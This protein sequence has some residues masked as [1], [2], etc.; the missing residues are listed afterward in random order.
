MK[1]ARLW[2]TW[3]KRLLVFPPIILAIIAYAW[4]VKHSP[5]L[6]MHAEEEASR[7][8]ETIV[9]ERMDV[10]PMV[11][12]FGTAKYAR[13]WRAV[14]Q[15]EG[16]IRKIHPE[17]RAG[18]RIQDAEL[19]LEIDDSDYQS[20]VDELNA[21]ID[22]QNAEI[23]QLKQ[24][25]L[26]NQKKL[27]LENEVL[28]IL[29]RE[30][31]REQTLLSQQAGSGSSFD[32]KRREL[33]AQVN[34]VQD[35]GN[36]IA[37]IKPQT[38][39]LQA[40]L[41]Q[42]EVQKEQALRDIERTKITAPFDMLV[43]SVQLEVGQFVSVGEQ[44]FVGYS[45]T[46][47][48]VEVQL[49]LQDIHRLF[50]SESGDVEPRQTLT[51]ETFRKMF[52]FDALVKVNGTNS[53]ESYHGR[54]LRVREIVDTQ[55][56]MVGFVVGVENVSPPE[57]KTPQP[58]LLEGAFCDVD[59]FGTPLPDQVVIPRR[60]IRN[61]SVYL[62]DDQNRLTQK[63]IRLTFAQD[64]YA[65]VASGLDDGETLVIVNPSPAIIGML[66]T[67]IQSHEDAKKLIASVI[68]GDDALNAGDDALI[69]GDDALIAGDDALRTDTETP[70]PKTD[71]Q[72]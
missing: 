9:V 27:A 58:P 43:G 19:L 33:L 49:P 5:P 37:L 45:G 41:R 35:L 62:V 51:P 64:D 40:G 31:D 47:M 23:E 15:V 26:N 59:I 53:T 54:F 18:S 69:A 29:Q 12:G 60:A 30:F 6:A 56:K 71:R 10:R 13:S 34:A 66:V 2:G 1:S 48:E 57:Q 65:V 24:S 17:L 38:K 21:A 20:R 28:E 16:R 7:M 61:D 44:L 36:S 72:D 68:A 11:S 55:T 4:L 52:Q 39:A 3:G 25:L 63:N 67:P 70:L 32:A 42:S 14:T 8:L 50:V 22:R 46:E